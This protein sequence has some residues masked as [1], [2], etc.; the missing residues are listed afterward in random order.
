[1]ST[2]TAGFAGKEEKK[3]WQREGSGLG[4]DKHR[5]DDMLDLPR[6][7]SKKH[8]PMSIEERAVQFA[9]FAALVGHKE[10]V[11]EVEDGEVGEELEVVEELL[12]ETETTEEGEELGE[13]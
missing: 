2:N 11:K 7:V 8:R 5:Y 13:L 3:A 12:E 6:H 1:M 9:P 10:L 4:L